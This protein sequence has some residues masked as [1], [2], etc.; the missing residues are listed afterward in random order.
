[1]LR[2]SKLADYSTVI[3]VYLAKIEQLKNVTD[4]ALATSLSKPTVSKLVKRL[5]DSNLLLSEL[6]A[7]GGYRL[8][9]P[10][11]CI[12][13]AHIINAIEQRNGLTECSDHNSR[14]S[15]QLSCQIS[16]HWQLIDK[17][18]DGVLSQITLLELIQPSSKLRLDPIIKHVKREIL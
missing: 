12:S 14:C 13:I 8:A 16:K 3:M 18:I 10:P 2:I 9:H 5:V 4:I 17:A 6:G 7:K 11:K 1:M 15:L